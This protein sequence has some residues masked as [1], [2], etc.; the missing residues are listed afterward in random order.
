MSPQ[1]IFQNVWSY[2]VP[3]GSILTRLL[4]TV[5]GLLLMAVAIAAPPRILDA[6]WL[7]RERKAKGK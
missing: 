7:R 2:P 6:L 5:G 3:W 1:E 4:W